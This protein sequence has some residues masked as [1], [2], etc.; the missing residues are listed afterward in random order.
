MRAL[1]SLLLIL[2]P[3]SGALCRPGDKE[4]WLEQAKLYFAK[5]EWEKS[6]QATLRALQA[7]PRLVPAEMLLGQVAATQAQFREAEK[8]FLRVLSLEPQDE[9]A[10]GYLGSAYLE[11]KRFVDARQVVE[12]LLRLDPANPAAR[13]ELGIIALALEEPSEAV[14]HFRKVLQADPSNATALMGLLESQ[15]LLRRRAEARLSAQK[16]TRLLSPRDP[17]YFRVASLLA[18]HQDYVAA[19]PLMENVQREFPQSYEVNFNL[20]LA[21]FDAQA[22]E[23]AAET[24]GPLIS[25]EPRAEAYNLLAMVEEQRQRYLEAVRAFQKAAELDPRNEDYRFDYGYELLR[26]QTTDAAIA[27]FASGVRDFPNSGKMRVGLGCAHYVAGK[28]E[29]AAQSILQATTLDPHNRLAYFFLGKV[30]EKA[31]ALQ[32]A[33][34]DKFQAYVQQRPDDP[35]S[36]YHYGIILYLRSQADPHPDY[37]PVKSCLGKAIH[38]NPGFSEAYLQL[39]I[40]S[41]REG[42]FDRSVGFLARAVQANPKLAAAHYRLGQAYTRLGQGEKAKLEFALFKK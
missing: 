40:I 20:A 8:H 37:E 19:I 6:R 27:V 29:E 33:I 31:Y 15:L 18:A 30:Y 24:L 4:A 13:C 42:Q 34:S 28:Y 7:G 32:D 9:I 35:W 5:G 11:E 10:L 38:L 23:K 22:Y 1:I 26:H 3:A 25:H 41:Q 2:A 16:L 14:S 36:Y 17:R 39:G 21:Y 12:R